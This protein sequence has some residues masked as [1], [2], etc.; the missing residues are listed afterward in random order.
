MRVSLKMKKLPP[1]TLQILRK[2]HIIIS[3]TSVYIYIY[4]SY[5]DLTSI[6]IEG[7]TK[8]YYIHKKKKMYKYKNVPLLFI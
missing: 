8:N 6:S 1:I 3:Y 2:H 7:D 4:I 5:D